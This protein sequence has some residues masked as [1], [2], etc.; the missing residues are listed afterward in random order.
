MKLLILIS[1]RE[2]INN[3]IFSNCRFNFSSFFPS[4]LFNLINYLFF[5]CNFTY[6][7]YIF[8]L[9]E[10]FLLFKMVI[11][12]S[13]V[14]HLIPLLFSAF[15]LCCVVNPLYFKL[16]IRVLHL[17]LRLKLIIFSLHASL[18]PLSRFMCF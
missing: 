17:I 14:S 15:F 7:S 13:M 2:S 5:M 12:P 10:R 9:L 1:S 16:W 8:S 3:P 6:V 4:I 11:I 18:L